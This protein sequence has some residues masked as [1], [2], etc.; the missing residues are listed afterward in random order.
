MVFSA[1]L[2]LY[3]VRCTERSYRTPYGVARRGR[4]SR[5]G[6][7]VRSMAL[8][9]AARSRY[10]AQFASRLPPRF[11]RCRVILPQEPGIGA[12]PHKCANAASLRS[13]WGLSPAAT[14]SAA[15][16]VAGLVAAWSRAAVVTSSA[17][18]RRR[19]RARSPSGAVPSSAGRSLTP[20]GG[21]APSSQPRWWA[22]TPAWPARYSYPVP[23]KPTSSWPWC[24]AA[25]AAALLEVCGF[26]GP[27][28]IPRELLAQQLDPSR[29]AAPAGTRP[30]RR[31]CSGRRATPLRA[32]QGQRTGAERASAVAASRP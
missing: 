18:G 17:G 27:E 21:C 1:M 22:T 10:N 32:G 12:T 30:V 13:R 24:G 20:S 6:G 26:L 31:G 29:R 25:G 19:S 8:P 28:E 23:T 5:R 9:Q 2:H 3:S 4:P 15:V 7:L 11:S 14:S 16:G